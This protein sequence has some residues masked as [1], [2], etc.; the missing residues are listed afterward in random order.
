LR[1]SKKDPYVNKDRSK[2]DDWMTMD[3]PRETNLKNWLYLGKDN[4][5]IDIEESRKPKKAFDFYKTIENIISYLNEN[6]FSYFDLNE[7]TAWGAVNRVSA[8]LENLVTD[9]EIHGVVGMSGVR[10]LSKAYQK[11]E[12]ADNL[13]E[14]ELLL[15]AEELLVE[16][17]NTK[18]AKIMS[19]Y[20]L[21][22]MLLKKISQMEEGYSSF[23]FDEDDEDITLPGGMIRLSQ[24]DYGTYLIEDMDTGED[25]LVQSDY[26]FP[27]IAMTFGWSGD[28][29]DI[30]G[31]I[32]FLDDHIGET[33]ED[34]G[35][36]SKEAAQEPTEHTSLNSDHLEALIHRALT[37]AVTEMIDP[38][39][40]EAAQ[41]ALR[42]NPKFVD[43]DLEALKDYMQK[44]AIRVVENYE[45]EM[46]KTIVNEFGNYIEYS[47]YPRLEETLESLAR[48]TLEFIEDD[49]SYEFGVRLLDNVEFAVGDFMD[50]FIHDLREVEE[51]PYQY[52][53]QQRRDNFPL[54]KDKKSQVD[55]VPSSPSEVASQYDWESIKNELP[56]RAWV[57]NQG[58]STTREV[59]L[60]TFTGSDEEFE[61]LVYS[62]KQHGV[63][64]ELDHGGEMYAVQYQNPEKHYMKG[65]KAQEDLVRGYDKPRSEVKKMFEE[66]SPERLY[67]YINNE[68]FGSIEENN[69]IEEVVREKGYM[70][71]FNDWWE[72]ATAGDTHYS[73]DYYDGY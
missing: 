65:R 51:D 71:Q 67:S 26:A 69:I 57:N 49:F 44:W 3:E 53:E 24:G 42:N 32:A 7:D 17:L 14:S 29:E 5:D 25:I 70:D 48:G 73:E 43:Y 66:M 12:Q 54:L 22:N 1:F 55:W 30:E 52:S 27:S 39:L 45:D 21:D 8:Q 41:T 33:A 2:S 47:D 40:D 4:P 20:D 19:R 61:E 34:P 6:V 10:M 50:A 58:F 37:S 9:P 63:D 16:L 38:S 35:Y 60:G 68:T 59:P 56:N 18:R 11:V 36:F 46:W 64:I 72:D 28:E 23:G 62:A 15:E 13:R 31:A